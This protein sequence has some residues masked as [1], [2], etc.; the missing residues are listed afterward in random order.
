MGG[1]FYPD[2]SWQSASAAARDPY[3]GMQ[4]PCPECGLEHES[5]KCAAEGEDGA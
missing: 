5:R 1:D 3:Y 4:A 2:L